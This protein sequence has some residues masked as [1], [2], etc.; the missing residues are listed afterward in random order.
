MDE[1]KPLQ[2]R[3]PG[4]QSGIAPI[5]PSGPVPGRRRLLTGGLSATGVVLTLASRPVLGNVTCQDPSAYGSVSVA[6]Q[7]TRQA[8]P[9][10]NPLSITDWG[11]A[12]PATWPVPQSTLFSAKFPGGVETTM[13]ALLQDTASTRRLERYVIASFLNIKANRIPRTCLNAPELKE[14]WN[15][16]KL[17]GLYRP[18]TL[19]WDSEAVIRY[20]QNNTVG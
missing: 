11:T 12:A 17:G 6:S 18:N 13:L 16:V 1:Q 15:A 10:T 7:E 20:L 3:D 5:P 14:M 9:T 2:D 8:I 4:P 19:R